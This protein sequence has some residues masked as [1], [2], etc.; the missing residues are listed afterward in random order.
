MAEKIWF[1]EFPLYQYEQDVVA[2]AQENG[3]TI[4][5]ARFDD[6]TGVTDAPEIVRIG[7]SKPSR[8]QKVAG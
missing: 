3:L 4:V 7:E 8:R 2:L 1:V 6:G 5:D